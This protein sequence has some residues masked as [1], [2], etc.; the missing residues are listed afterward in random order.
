MFHRLV[1][2]SDLS[3]GLMGYGI[4]EISGRFCIDKTYGVRYE[5][6]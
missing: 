5:P 6:E 4:F 1:L 3:L 2:V